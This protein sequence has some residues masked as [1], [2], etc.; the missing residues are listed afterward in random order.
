MPRR[1]IIVGT[2]RA[3][4]FLHFGA[5]KAAGA[6][7]LAFVDVNLEKAQQASKSLGVPRFFGSVEEAL[8]KLK[9]VDFVDVC[10]SASTHLSIAKLALEHGCHVIIEKPIT[11]TLEEADEL[12][13]LRAKHKKVVCAV[14]NHRFYPGIEGLRE[15]VKSGD[16]GEIVSIH[17]EMSFP[18]ANVGMMDVDHW[19]H[20]IPGGR[21]FEANPHNL[22]LIHSMVGEMEFV[23]IFPRKLHPERY[24]HSEIDEFHAVLRTKSCSISVKM[25][26]HLDQEAYGGK[27]GS[28][29]IVIVGTK[30]SVVANY[31]DF[32]DLRSIGEVTKSDIV[33]KFRD[34]FAPKASTE[35]VVKNASGEPVNIG[36]GSG[37][38]WVLERFIGHI[39]GRY[40]A[41]AVPFE[42]AYFVQKMNSL[43]GNRA[44][45]KIKS[46]K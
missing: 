39:D 5:L 17:R 11:E 36:T 41:E 20:T 38:R 33:A 4:T 42:E 30:G 27:H 26:M 18:H 25:S 28:N 34:R 19:S 6:E 3:G 31:H 12:S 43:M 23:D 35:P 10:T 7:I 16:L 15:K 45:E 44:A 40:P 21:L 29:F 24:P 14:H 46:A 2:G 13:R 32:Y 8:T 37:H 9:D 22:Y 1:G